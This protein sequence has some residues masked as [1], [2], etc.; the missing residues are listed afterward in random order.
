VSEEKPLVP[1]ALGAVPKGVIN[2]IESLGLLINWSKTCEPSQ[3]M[4]YL[5]IQ[6]DCVN[7]RL[8]LPDEKLEKF[9]VLVDEW[10]RRKRVT[11]LELQGFLGKLNWAARVVRGGRTFLHR[12]INLLCHVRDSHHHVRITTLAKEDINWWKSGLLHFHGHYKFAC[13]ISLPSFVFACDAS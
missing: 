4:T 7:R 11:K 10:S 3:L 13:D 2:L 9:R 1:S 5:G 12:L 6:I 8:T